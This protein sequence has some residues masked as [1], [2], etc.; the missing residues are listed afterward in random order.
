[1][2][3]RFMEGSCASG[4]VVNLVLPLRLQLPPLVSM[5]PAGA[6]KEVIV[7]PRLSVGCPLGGGRQMETICSPIGN[8][9][10]LPG[11]GIAATAYCTVLPS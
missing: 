9:C 1:M 7:E 3:T 5:Q 2:E 8:P 4:T 6:V 11:A 10:E